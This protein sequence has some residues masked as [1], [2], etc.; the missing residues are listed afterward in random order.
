MVFCVDSY[1]TQNLFFHRLNRIYSDFSKNQK[2]IKLRTVKLRKVKEF[3]SPPRNTKLGKVPSSKKI[4]LAP[5]VSNL[6]PQKCFGACFFFMKTYKNWGKTCPNLVFSQ[7]IENPPIFNRFFFLG[8]E[9]PESRTYA[10]PWTW[11]F[12][13]DIRPDIWPDVRPDVRPD[14]RPDVRLDIG[15]DIIHG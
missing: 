11:G 6:P 15:L 13:P 5:L 8:G 9:I 14:I 3:A 7:K 1:C 10:Q 4:G 12:T 2:N